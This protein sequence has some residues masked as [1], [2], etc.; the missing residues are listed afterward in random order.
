MS[1]IWAIRGFMVLQL[2]IFLAAASIHFGLLLEGYGH[3]V[4]GTAESVIAAVLLLVS[5]SPGRHHPG[6]A[7]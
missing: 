6:R 5:S 2:A 1:G 7:G 3:R 4:A